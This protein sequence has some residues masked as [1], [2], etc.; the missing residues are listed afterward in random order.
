MRARGLAI[1]AIC[2]CVCANLAWAKPTFIAGWAVIKGVHRIDTGLIK[3]DPLLL[4]A[5]GKNNPNDQ[6][7]G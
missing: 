7:R 1:S 2:L 4:I 3:T 6:G 5:R